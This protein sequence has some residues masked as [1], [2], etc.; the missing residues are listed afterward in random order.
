SYFASTST[1]NGY[2]ISQEGS[3]SAFF[4]NTHPVYIGSGSWD[5]TNI[6]INDE[7]SMLP[8]LKTDNY[9][10]DGIC[11]NKF[12]ENCYNCL[13]DCQCTGTKKCQGVGVCLDPPTPSLFF[14]NPTQQNNY[15]TNNRF[16]EFGVSIDNPFPKNFKLNWN[17]TN[18]TIYNESLVLMYNFG[19]R[20]E[21]GE[22]PTKVNDSSKYGNN[23]T[24][25]G[26]TW[27]SSGKYDG[28]YSFDGVND[29]ID[30]GNNVS[31]KPKRVTISAWAKTSSSGNNFFIAGFG[32]D[33]TAKQGYWIGMNA[34]GKAMS[35]LGTTSGYSWMVG[36]YINDNQWH[37]ITLVYDGTAARIYVDGIFRDVSNNLN[38]DIT[39]TGLG[40][41]TVGKGDSLIPANYWNGLIDEVRIWNASLS[42][43]EVK[44]SYISNLQ[45]YNQSQ[46][47][48][49][50]NQSNI[51]VNSITELDFGNYS[52]QAFSA[53]I[54]NSEGQTESRNVSIVPVGVMQVF[55]S[56]M[57]GT[58][59]NT[60]DLRDRVKLNVAGSQLIGR[61]EYE[62]YESVPLWW[63]KKVFS[64]TNESG[65]ATWMADQSGTYWFRARRE[66]D[67]E[68]IKTTD[69]S[70]PDFRYLE[71]GGIEN[72]FL[73]FINITSPK[74]GEFYLNTEIIDFN[75]TSYDED[76]FFDFVW[77]LDDN[78]TK[79]GDSINQNN[80]NFRFN[81][82]ISS[83][84]KNIE[85]NIVDGRG[86]RASDSKT[87]F[88]INTGEIANYTFAYINK[89]LYG[90]DIKGPLIKFNA[91]KSFAIE[92]NSTRDITCIGGDCPATTT[93]GTLI[94]NSYGLR[95]NYNGMN[96]SW[97]FDDG[98]RYY[99]RGSNGTNFTKVFGTSGQHEAN[100][101][102]IIPNANSL[103]DTTFDINLVNYCESDGL[104]YWNESGSSFNTLISSTGCGGLDK[105]PGGNDDCC[106]ANFGCTPT[107][108]S[109]NKTLQTICGNISF[110]SDYKDSTNC[111]LDLCRVGS[112]SACGGI[113]ETGA[114]CGDDFFV[115]IN[116][117]CKY[118]LGLG[119]CELN[120][121]VRGSIFQDNDEIIYYCNTTTSH[122][123]CNTQNGLM[124]VQMNSTL[125]GAS[126]TCDLNESLCST[127]QGSVACGAAR[128]RL[129]FFSFFNF[130]LSFI[131]IFVV[132]SIIALK[133][134]IC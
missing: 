56:N 39:Y 117:S 37:Y 47:Y 84:Q 131:L 59:I 67:V 89:P 44:E 97:T 30:A 15:Q 16:Y 112:D 99:V 33:T 45:K 36:S 46:W 72:N 8:Y 32:G 38:A 61:V 65:F 55:W 124:R 108:C 101:E 92:I 40:S 127:E 114:N 51:S 94:Y 58:P 52:Y 77:N 54:I 100:L 107:G 64:Q 3:P 128:V 116:C 11:E 126:G 69:N 75:Q 104:R 73:P 93:G 85:L 28:A 96:F 79:S 125:A 68:W 105:T 18:Y 21:L 5:F 41:L 63:D 90:E 50:V 78:I 121:E 27:I 106:P 49:Y 62:I 31:L 88:V 53:N 122:G 74:T 118:N 22:N 48:L 2:G 120:S 91:T 82:Y 133:K 24:V 12:I 34:E 130:V 81:D 17:G 110:C 10:G 4:T 20:D 26:A 43:S 86:A 132:Y 119:K 83:G 80:Y 129:P 98:D 113:I 95:N 14:T 35:Y 111:S 123:E 19:N 57:I 25:N 60:V 13:Y 109:L 23:G 134:K 9:C 70:N 115:K 103:T 76:D 71:V 29:Y 42:D 66:G 87:I 6:W 102:V 1:N 7:N